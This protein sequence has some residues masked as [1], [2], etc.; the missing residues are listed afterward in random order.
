M[1]RPLERSLN[2]RINILHVIEQLPFGGAE[3]LLLTLA[4]NIDKRKIKLTF[5]CLKHEGYIVKILRNEGFNVIFLGNYK[6]RHFYKEII[7]IIKLI[8]MRDIMYSRGPDDAG[9]YIGEHIGLGH[10]RLSIIDL[11]ASGHQPMANADKTIWMV[12]NGEIY[13][14]KDLRKKLEELGHVFKSRTDC[15]VVIHGYEE[16]GENVF[17]NLN[18]MF[19]VAIWDANKNALI[20]ARDRVGKKPLFYSEHNGSV[21]FASD[22]KSVI[23]GLGTVPE[24]DIKSM[25][26]YL[27]YLNV[28][29]P[30]S[31]YK[32]IKKLSPAHYIVFRKN[33]TNIK[34]YWFLSFRDKI[35]MKEDQCLHEITK[36]L[37]LAIKDRLA[38]DVPL[39]AFLSGGIDSSLVV[40]LM[41]KLSP[42]KVKT[43]SIGFED[44][45]YNELPYAKKM[46][47]RYDTDHHEFILKP[48]YLDIIPQLIWNY[49]EPFADSSALPSYYVSKIAHEHIKVA[50]VGDGGDESFAGYPRTKEV[51]IASLY[52][53][54]IPKLLSN[55]IISPFLRIAGN[56]LDNYY[57]IN[58]IKFYE[59]YTKETTRS[60][61]K[62]YM[63]WINR[64]NDLYSTN[65]KGNLNGYNPS[66]IYEDY[67]DMED[68]I[69]DIDRALFTDINTILPNG[70]QVKM[71]V[72]SMSNSLEV[73]AP[74]LDYRILEFA[75][76]IPPLIK[77]KKGTLKY[78]LKKLAEE[79]LPTESIHRP[80]WGFAI[81]IDDWFRKELKPYLYSVIL[82]DKSR[83]RKYFNYDYVEYI[84][85]EHLADKGYH[86]HKLWSLLWLEL[87]HRMFIDKDLKP[88][89]SLR[90]L[91]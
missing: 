67:F 11:T 52:R 55:I 14:F 35:N 66:H 39:G 2:N 7:D 12:F 68:D 63:G 80:K 77:L 42:E 9:V 53:K 75:A 79:Y 81:P 76:S 51:Y 41:S 50:L 62:M 88:S 29:H 71:D 23:E 46:A 34:R 59:N 85:D 28:P 6:T 72:A 10:R 37:N 27:T 16:W 47:D 22:I 13:N 4:R 25:D 33:S 3:N 49:G 57:L 36:L 74:F 43:F 91:L 65:F 87:W 45:S 78:L 21:V 17:K 20:L 82:S 19:G 40:A 84:I 5:L 8:K 73:R 58:R 32:K 86:E 70:Y 89:D 38:S 83:K 69:S 44:E 15:E 24:I 31:I 48:D 64:R 56:A 61:Y 26:A 60:R 30:Q 18:G 90:D 54:R 1:N